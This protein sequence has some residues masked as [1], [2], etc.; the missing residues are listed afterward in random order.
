MRRPRTP[1]TTTTEPSADEPRRPAGWERRQPGGAIRPEDVHRVGQ[2]VAD[3]DPSPGGGG[4]VVGL[5]ADRGLGG[6]RAV[7]QGQPVEASLLSEERGAGRP[8]PRAAWRAAPA[9]GTGPAR[10]RWPRRPALRRRGCGRRRRWCR[11]SVPHQS[12]GLA[13]QG[14]D[15]AGQVAGGRRGRGWLGYVGAWL[16]RSGSVP[17]GNGHKERRGH[18]PSGEQQ[19]SRPARLV[20]V[21][22]TW[23]SGRG[24]P[25]VR[26]SAGHESVCWGGSGGRKGWVALKSPIT[27]P[28][29]SAS[30]MRM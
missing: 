15:A 1:I 20:A 9:R 16:P 12:L 25:A 21:G 4:G 17:A 8:A 3:E 28:A 29:T 10:R 26:K 5:A 6:H 19:P 11:W 24:R 30:R 14:D 18:R 2:L 7:R 13:R 23:C 27:Q 22:H